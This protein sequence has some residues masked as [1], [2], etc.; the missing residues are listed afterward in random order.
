MLGVGV[1][2]GPSPALWQQAGTSCLTF[3]V[4]GTALLL[5]AHICSCLPACLLASTLSLCSL[6]CRFEYTGGLAAQQEE[7]AA[8]AG[9]QLEGKENTNLE[10]QQKPHQ[11]QGMPS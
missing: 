10:Q 2:G 5:P 11:K 3:A 1:K 8:G 6:T 9:E 4:P 7:P